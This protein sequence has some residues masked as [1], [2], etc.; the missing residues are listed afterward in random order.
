[1]MEL[2]SATG[3][4][5]E[6][7]LMHV[8]FDSS[9]AH[10]MQ[11][12]ISCSAVALL[13]VITNF[14]LKLIIIRIIK[15]W[16]KNSKNTYDDVFYEKG[17]F[18]SLSHLAPIILILTIG[19]IPIAQYE[20]LVSFVKTA[21]Y[22]YLLITITRTIIYII[23]ALH[24]IYT[25]IPMAQH[26]SINGYIQSIK[27]IF[28]VIG[29]VL[30]LSLI[31]KK[32]VN[33]LLAG[34]TAFAAVLIFVFKDIIMGLI[35]GIQISANDIVR[36]G[37]TIEM[38]KRDTEG[39]VIDITLSTVK[40]LNSNRTISTIPAYALVTESFQNWRGLEIAGG[41]R[42][43]R[44]FNIDMRSIGF[45]DKALLS[46]LESNPHLADKMKKIKPEI[47]NDLQLTNIGIL[48]AYLDQ[49]LKHHPDVNNTATILVRHLEPTENGLPVELLAYSTIIDGSLHEELQNRIFEHIYA[50]IREFDLRVFQR[51]TGGDVI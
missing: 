46:R 15:K 4:M 2:F 34:I 51:P 21:T 33:T 41:R 10:V 9:I 6:T 22:I 18:N 1:M 40:V 12:L 24:E 29:G 44:R 39:K 8:G 27:V 49:Y 47:L 50:I 28:Y 23:D 31:L 16:I 14:I 17:V 25:R 35:A 11:I 32:D 7:R 36:V 3:S 5:I 43:K 30:A 38:P 13:A 26:R 48:C 19:L 37:D 45:A 42:I 20:N